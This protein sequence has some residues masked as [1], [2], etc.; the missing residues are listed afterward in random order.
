MND[1][2][3]R[4]QRPNPAREPALIPEHYTLQLPRAATNMKAKRPD[5]VVLCL[6]SAAPP[7]RRGWRHSWNR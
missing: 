7:S 2:T 4:A 3:G 5:D 1:R 6:R